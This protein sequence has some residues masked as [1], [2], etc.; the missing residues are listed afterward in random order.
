[1]NT[2]QADTSFS[3]IETTQPKISSRLIILRNLS[4]K[5]SITDK[6]VADI[7]LT[8]KSQATHLSNKPSA[9]IPFRTDL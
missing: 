7:S 6:S 8:D 5:T 2:F 9:D 3:L 1:M 4:A